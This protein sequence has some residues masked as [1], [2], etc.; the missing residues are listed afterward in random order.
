MQILLLGACTSQLLLPNFSIT[1]KVVL[2][3]YLL[4]HRQHNFD[5]I[6]G[7][8][9]VSSK[10]RLCL[11][12]TIRCCNAIVNC[13]ALPATASHHDSPSKLYNKAKRK[14]RHNTTARAHRRRVQELLPVCPL[15][16]TQLAARRCSQVEMCPTRANTGL[17]SRHRRTPTPVLRD[18]PPGMVIG[19]IRCPR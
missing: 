5:S 19:A 17:L 7:P 9:K 1:C 14:T 6:P 12:V 4:K 10:L 15:Q 11:W 16:R 13:T 8:S 18:F 2:L 3:F